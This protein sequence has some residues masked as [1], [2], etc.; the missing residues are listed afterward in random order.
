VHHGDPGTLRDLFNSER[1]RG[2]DNL[3]VS[4]RQ[5]IVWSAIPSAVQPILDAILL[6]TGVVGLLGWLAGRGGGL[7]AV[8]VALL[9]LVG[10][11]FLKVLR[12]AGRGNTRSN[13]GVLQALVAACVY[14]VARAVALFTRTPH[15][16]T[17]PTTA[18]TIA[19]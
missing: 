6:V 18:A 4:F 19:S 14:D 17:R 12:A 7:I 3:R 10:G 16:S 9:M 2:R 15:R 1:W 11:A 8:S 5:P 13:V